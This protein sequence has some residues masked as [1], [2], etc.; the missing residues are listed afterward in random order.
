MQ[1]PRIIPKPSAPTPASSSWKNCLPWN[2]SL[3][4]K[5]LGTTA[6]RNL[7]SLSLLDS[8]ALSLWWT[9]YHPISWSVWPSSQWPRLCC[10]QLWGCINSFCS[11]WVGGRGKL[12]AAVPQTLHLGNADTF[13]LGH[14][15]N[16]LKSIRTLQD[17]RMKPEETIC[18]RSL[19]K[20]PISGWE[21]AS[22]L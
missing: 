8:F 22:S 2:Q 3:V 12:L 16:D 17:G 14:G 21:P 1:C 10:V 5:R 13:S 18:L 9:A 11:S 20:K 6:L 15:S 19:L 7:F 4:P